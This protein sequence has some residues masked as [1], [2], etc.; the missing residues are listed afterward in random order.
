MFYSN[1]IVFSDT[2]IIDDITWVSKQDMFGRNN[3]TPIAD[4]GRMVVNSIESMSGGR[5]L[6]GLRGRGSS[7][8]PFLVIED[9]QKKAELSFRE[10][11][12]SLQNE[13]QGTE[14]KLK[15]IQSNQLD[16][17]ESKTSEQ[18]KAIE[19]FQRKILS[20]R[21]QLR[22]VQ[23]QLNADIERLE[24]NIKVLN[25][26]TMPLIVIILYFFIKVFTEKRRKEFYRKIG[27]LENK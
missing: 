23:R 19:E 13:L 6:I 16:S 5:N 22:D 2:D 21:K 14:D 7:N 26:W 11:Q 10:K 17:S 15:E 25:I 24:N 18:N 8:R 12:I 4:N 9:L 3:P 27:R 20:I 1:I